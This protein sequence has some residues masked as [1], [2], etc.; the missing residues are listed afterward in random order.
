M[1]FR[2]VIGTVLRETHEGPDGEPNA[3]YSLWILLPF[4][5]FNWNRQ[6]FVRKEWFCFES[7]AEGNIGETLSSDELSDAR[8]NP[9]GKI[10]LEQPGED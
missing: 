4:P 1:K 9:A 8:V 10:V 3:G 2:E 5:F 6:R 7:T